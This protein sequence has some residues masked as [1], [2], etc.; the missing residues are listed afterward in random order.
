MLPPLRK[1]S[2]LH[3]DSSSNA[4]IL[5]EQ[6]QSVFTQ[7]N[8]SPLAKIRGEP[9]PD[10]EKLLIDEKGVAKLHRNLNPAKASGPDN[11]PNIILKTCADNIAP[12]L[13]AIFNCSLKTGQLPT[14]WLSANI[15]SV[16]KK[17]D[18][19][20]AENYRPVSLTSVSCKLLEHIISHHL[21]LH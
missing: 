10:L 12:S 3:S 21:H 14:D 17:G 9:F 4:K 15:S 2:T 16:F 20:K 19:N 13:T 5:L 1:E 18:R 11:I 8:S 7:D 6:F